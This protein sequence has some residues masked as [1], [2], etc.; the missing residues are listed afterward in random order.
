MAMSIETKATL[1]SDAIKEDRTELRQLK[2]RIHSLVTFIVVSSFAIT[3]FVV[4]PTEGAAHG[5]ELEHSSRIVVALT[6][7]ALLAILWT[8]S[9]RLIS[10]LNEA[11]KCVELREDL[12]RKLDKGE[13]EAIDVYSDAS[14]HKAKVNHRVLFWIVTAAS[15]AIL[16]KLSIMFV[17]PAPA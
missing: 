6:D 7:A 4:R 11:Q 17:M 9:A 1:I 12:L 13:I 10:D 15:L 3:A 8:L 5:L 16:I 2:E 14:S